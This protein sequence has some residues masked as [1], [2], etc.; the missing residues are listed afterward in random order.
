VP[1]PTPGG[2]AN[3][4]QTAKNYLAHRKEQCGSNTINLSNQAH[5]SSQ[6]F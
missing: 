6:F 3:L 5:M 4:T 1:I 2:Q